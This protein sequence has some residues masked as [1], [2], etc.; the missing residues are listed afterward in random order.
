MN[1]EALQILHA[2]QIK[3]PDHSLAGEARQYIEALNKLAAIG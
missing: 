1:K 3:F 2:I